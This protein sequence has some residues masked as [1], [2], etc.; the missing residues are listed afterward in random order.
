MSYV[1]VG[2]Y[3]VEESDESMWPFSET[4]YVVTSEDPENVHEWFEPLQA[5]SIGPDMTGTK[6]LPEIPN[7]HEVCVAWWD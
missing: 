1:L 6:N 4:I 7:G 5:D 2:I 3:E